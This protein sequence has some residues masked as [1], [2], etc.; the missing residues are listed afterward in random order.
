MYMEVKMK[1]EERLLYGE[2]TTELTR[3][4]ESSILTRKERDQPRVTTPTSDSISTDHSTSDQ[5]CQ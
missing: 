3:N 5:E 1:K 4:G 2:D